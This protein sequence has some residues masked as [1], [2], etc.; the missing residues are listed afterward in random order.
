MSTRHRHHLVVASLLASTLLGAAP[1]RAGGFEIPESGT[2]ALGRGGAFIVLANDPTAMI[3]NPGGLRRLR[4]THL[5]Y[6]HALVFEH[7]TFT[8][9]PSDLPPGT[10]YGFDPLAPVSN[11]DTIFALGGTLIATTDFGLADWTFAA[12]VYGPNAH[13][14]RTYPTE[15]GQ[16]YMLTSLEAVLLMPS[17]AVAYG[18]DDCFGVGVTFQYVMAPSLDMGLVVD[19]SQAGGLHAYYSGNDV[20]A[21]IAMSDMAS[22]SAIVGG[23][24]RPIPE[25]ELGVAGRVVPAALNLEG[26]FS[27]KNIPGQTQF[28]E[29]QLTVPG[30]AARLDLTLPITVKGGLRYRHLDGAREVFDVELDVAYE[31][32]S[33]LERYD[34]QLD[35]TINLF[36]GAEAPDTVIEKRW[37]DTLSVRLGGTWNA[38]DNEANALQIS[39][40]AYWESAAVPA[41]YEHLDFLAF[42]RVGLGF[43]L[44][45]RFG[46]LTLRAS[47]SHVFQEDREVSERTGK[48]Y[49]QRP[50]DPCPGTCD[51]GAGWSGV[52]SNAGRFESGYDLLSLGLDAAF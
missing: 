24:W 29:Q 7:S 13:G 6:N 19:G 41:N 14:Q 50:L 20:E 42:Q 25:L 46:G 37:K 38:I 23:W 35:G 12:G 32:W 17:L 28:S 27:L 48:V 40:G 52:P 11:G 45:G 30:S 39:L 47:Y 8:R 2:V 51:G 26:K 22:F 34:V 18:K 21:K 1:S 44:G 36:V 3:L 31:N 16:R 15:G 33:A 9:A 4:G 5:L 43:G 10:D 49:Q